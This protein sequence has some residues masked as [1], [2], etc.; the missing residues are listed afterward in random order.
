MKQ[1]TFGKQIGMGILLL[2]ASGALT[3]VLHNSVFLN[4]AWILYGLLYG[5]LF[6]IHPVYPEQAKFRYS[7]EGA[8]KIA[9]MAGL[10]C[11]AIGLITEF[12]V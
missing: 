3:A 7:E 2:F 10:I 8:Q 9:R 4:L 12:G 11:I 5:L 1:W 6:V